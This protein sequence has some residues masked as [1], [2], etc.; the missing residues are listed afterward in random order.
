[1]IQHSPN[2]IFIEIVFATI[3]ISIFLN[4]QADNDII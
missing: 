4:E 3:Q 2:P 1:M